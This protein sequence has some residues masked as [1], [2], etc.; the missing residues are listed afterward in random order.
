MKADQESLMDLQITASND[1]VQ[2]FDLTQSSSADESAPVGVPATSTTGSTLSAF[3]DA[4][5]AFNG[6]SLEGIMGEE[7]LSGSLFSSELLCF[8]AAP[9]AESSCYKRA[10]RL[11]ELFEDWREKV[12]ACEPEA[13]DFLVMRL[14]FALHHENEPPF[15]DF[16]RSKRLPKHVA[17]DRRDPISLLVTAVQLLHDGLP[18]RPRGRRSLDVGRFVY[19]LD[20]LREASLVK[21]A[22]RDMRFDALDALSDFVAAVIAKHDVDCPFSLE[23]Q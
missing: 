12:E 22:A 3:V 15:R 17:K 10:K 4:P 2:A 21:V 7:R 8:P 1:A 16:A 20:R 18:H 6:E 13:L 9:R 5:L 11:K 14:V 19:V 23:T